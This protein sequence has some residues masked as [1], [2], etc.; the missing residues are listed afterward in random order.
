MRI[1]LTICLVL[2]SALVFA[3][4]VIAHIIIYK[5]VMP[6]GQV[7][8]SERPQSGARTVEKS[9]VNIDDTGVRSISREAIEGANQRARKRSQA[10]DEV[11]KAVQIA[12][13]RLRAAEAEREAGREP[14]PGER[15]GIVGSDSGT[16]GPGPGTRLTEGY[17]QRQQML[18][19]HVEN[20]RRSLE[21]AQ[22][23]YANVR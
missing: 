10:L 3:P 8:Y 1:I 15:L 12:E 13:T 14:L 6:D 19:E 11:T 20:A 4:D 2:S 18:E 7:I 23:G 21:S 5:S 16:L 22:Q 17:F 9:V